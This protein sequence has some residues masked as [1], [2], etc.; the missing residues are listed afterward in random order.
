MSNDKTG[1]TV[2]EIEMFERLVR[3]ETKLDSTNNHLKEL[4]SSVAKQEVRI[5]HLEDTH[6]MIDGQNNITG[7]VKSFLYT[8]I[9]SIVTGILLAWLLFKLNLGGGV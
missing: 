9:G 2:D 7:R 1:R 6:L 3:I 4:N 8:N 5:R